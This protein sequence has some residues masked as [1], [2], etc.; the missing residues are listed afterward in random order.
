MYVISICPET[1][2]ARNVIITTSRKIKH[3]IASQLRRW[4][5]IKH[6]KIL[7]SHYDR[8]CCKIKIDG[9]NY[10]CNITAI[11]EFYAIGKLN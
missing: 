11:Y 5:E 3:K 4:L 9:V 2:V 6:F 10:S 1:F 8:L 7:L